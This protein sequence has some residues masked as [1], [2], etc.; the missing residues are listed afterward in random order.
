MKYTIYEETIEG[1]GSYPFEREGA[2][3]P[4]VGDILVVNTLD[5][6]VLEAVC[7][8]SHSE[9]KRKDCEVC[10]FDRDVCLSVPV[11]CRKEITFVLIESLLEAL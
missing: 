3:Q 6:R 10:P 4:T 7:V 9:Q 2:V 8:R 1:I 11:K 5:G